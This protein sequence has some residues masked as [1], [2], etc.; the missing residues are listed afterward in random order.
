MV[1]C[2]IKGGMMKNILLI[3]V[4]LSLLFTFCSQSNEAPY[5]PGKKV[6]TLQDKEYKKVIKNEDIP[7]NGEWDFNLQEEWRVDGAGDNPLVWVGSVWIDDD[8]TVYLLDGKYGKVAVFSSRGKFLFSFGEQGEGPGELMQPGS[9]FLVGKYLVIQDIGN[10]IHYFNKKGEFVNTFKYGMYT[11]PKDFLDEFTFIT[12]RSNPEKKQE[13]ETLEIHN[14]KT[15]E[16]AVI[17]EIISEVPV[18]ASN[19]EGSGSINIQIGDENLSIKVVT[20]IDTR[21]KEIYFGRN[22]NYVIKKTDPNGSGLLSFSIEGRKRKPVPLWYKKRLVEPIVIDGRKLSKK[23]ENKLIKNMP[24]QSNYF[25]NIFID[26]TGLIYVYVTDI[27]NKGGQEI[28]IFSSQGKY[29]YH[30]IIELPKELRKRG[31]LVIKGEHLFAF[32]ADEK[33]DRKLVKYK[34][35]KPSQ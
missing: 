25:N 20:G 9:L 34:I 35:K 10:K 32:A 28:D 12:L 29:L 2:L 30:A 22:D 33:D 17:A 6:L 11:R 1:S 19:G 24:D 7:V 18:E 13:K 4:W 27:T 31:T 23:M 3:F 15:E 5:I 14:I 21:H 16:K 26:E 8:G